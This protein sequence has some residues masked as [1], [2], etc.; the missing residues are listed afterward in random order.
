ME[1]VERRGAG[2]ETGEGRWGRGGEGKERR[3][4]GRE[5]GDAT[6]PVTLRAL[7]STFADNPGICLHTLH[8]RA[9]VVLKAQ[10]AVLWVRCLK[11]A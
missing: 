9:G 6:P 10:A 8:T 2:E 7:A 3:R 4:E 5:R 11:R 1:R